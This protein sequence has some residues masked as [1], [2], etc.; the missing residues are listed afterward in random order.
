M[1]SRSSRSSPASLTSWSEPTG[2]ASLAIAIAPGT[3]TPA[4]ALPVGALSERPQPAPRR[5]VAQRAGHPGVVE[6]PRLEAQRARRLVLAREVGLEHR[7]VVGR[8]R[9]GDARGGEPR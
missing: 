9:A 4:G 2:S 3:L 8:D 5:L 7:R 6:R 1:A